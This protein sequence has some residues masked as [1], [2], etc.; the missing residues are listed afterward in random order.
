[1]G[2]EDDLDSLS[3]LLDVIH[4]KFS[5]NKLNSGIVW[6]FLRTK[7]PPG[8]PEFTTFLIEDIDSWTKRHCVQVSSNYPKKEK[9]K[10]NVYEKLRQGSQI[11]HSL[12]HTHRHIKRQYEA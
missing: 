3:D 11:P 7:F 10:Q 4:L 12:T 2:Y 5:N 1:M 8:E 6:A 9:A